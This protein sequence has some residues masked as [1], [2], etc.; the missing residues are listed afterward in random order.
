MKGIRAVATVFEEKSAPRQGLLSAFRVV[1]VFMAL[2][3]I[4]RFLAEPV[5]SLAFALAGRDVAPVTPLAE[6]MAWLGLGILFAGPFER[7]MRKTEPGDIPGAL[8]AM[9]G[10][11]TGRSV[12]APPRMPMPSPRDPN[13]PPVEPL[14]KDAALDNSEAHNEGD[15]PA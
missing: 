12:S 1:L 13:A 10:S 15:E 9:F 3:W 8:V 4:V 11:F 2:A 14:P 6:P 7:W 5:S